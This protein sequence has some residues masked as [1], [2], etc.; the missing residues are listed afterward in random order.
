MEWPGSVPK[1]VHVRFVINKV[2]LRQI[3]LQKIQ[4]PPVNPHCNKC[5]VVTDTE[6]PADL[7]SF[8]CGVGNFHKIV[9]MGPNMKF[10][11]KNEE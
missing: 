6:P 1:A 9:C 7:L 10:S 2:A 3:F 11:T 4:F 5:C 8:L